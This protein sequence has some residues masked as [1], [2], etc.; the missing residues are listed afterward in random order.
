MDYFKQ[1]VEASNML[2]QYDERQRTLEENRKK[3]PRL[4]A[5]EAILEHILSYARAYPDLRFGQILT[6][7]GIATHKVEHSE[8]QHNKATV[9]ESD[10]TTWIE[11]FS[12]IFYEEST[13]TLKKLQDGART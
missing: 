12:D 1:Y 9:E 7:L 4:V 2:S 11:S 6:N 3:Y 8:P 5:N 13:D 10:F